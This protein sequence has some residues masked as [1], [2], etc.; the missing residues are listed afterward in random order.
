MKDFYP[1]SK[2]KEIEGLKDV[3]DY[4]GKGETLSDKQK[5]FILAGCYTL[6]WSKNKTVNIDDL[7]DFLLDNS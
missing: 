6:G 5:T 3:F 7:M 1:G 2:Y 4:F